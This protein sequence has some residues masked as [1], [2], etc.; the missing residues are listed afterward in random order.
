MKYAAQT[1]RAQTHPAHAQRPKSRG[2][3]FVAA[4]AAALALLAVGWAVNVH[5]SDDSQASVDPRQVQVAWADATFSPFAPAPGAQP[6]TD[7]VADV[8]A[9]ARGVPPDLAATAAVAPESALSE[10][11]ASMQEDVR[12]DGLQWA[13]GTGLDVPQDTLQ[14]LLANDSSDEVR[15]LALQGLTERPEAT[16]EEIRSILDSAATNPSAAVRADAARMIARMDEL[17]L[18]DEQARAFRGGAR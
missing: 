9:D 10:A 14:E 2:A 17:A 7:R 15:Q 3:A 6:V 8:Q 16:R 13:L 4:S 12:R 5:R 11:L 1:N 18:M